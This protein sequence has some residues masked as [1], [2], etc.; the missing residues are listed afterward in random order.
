LDVALN[1]GRILAPLGFGI[2]VQVD[3]FLDCITLMLEFASFMWLKY[4]RVARCVCAASNMLQVQGTECSS[5]VHSARRK[6]RR[7][8]HHHPQGLSL[9]SSLFPL[10]SPIQDSPFIHRLLS[11]SL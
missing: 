9:S 8:D 10:P 5:S 2:L 6:D 11:T 4:A 1:H 3:T 7:M